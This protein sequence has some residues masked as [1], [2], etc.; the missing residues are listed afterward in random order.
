MRLADTNIL[1][2]AADTS[3]QERVKR[4][5]AAEVLKEEQL[6]LST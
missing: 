5:G 2:Y 6:S 4:T 3:P 1:V